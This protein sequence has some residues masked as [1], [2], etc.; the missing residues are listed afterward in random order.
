[1]A[2]STAK[3]GLYASALAGAVG[4]GRLGWDRAR[5]DEA[6]FGESA[7][8]AGLAGA[9]GAALAATAFMGGR[10]IGF[11]NIAKA[12]GTTSFRASKGAIQ[13]G[14]SVIGGIYSGI[15]KFNKLPFV[16]KGAITVPAAL[17][18]S[19]AVMATS[20]AIS[21][22]GANAHAVRDNMGG[23]EYED[24]STVKDRLNMMQ[25]HGD[26]VLGLHNSRHG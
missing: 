7:A 9:S 13:T 19:G 2:I 18:I 25:T 24:A 8:A 12:A 11:S 10:M 23:Y 5:E 15:S 6:D 22:P 1:M 14:K 21:Q 20:K 16:V 17:A 3:L 26:M 4:L